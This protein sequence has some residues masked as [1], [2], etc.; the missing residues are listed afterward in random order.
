MSFCIRGGRHPAALVFSAFG[1]RET[2]GIVANSFRC[3]YDTRTRSR[4]FFMRKKKSNNDS[5]S[6]TQVKAKFEF[7]ARGKNEAEERI[8][9]GGKLLEASRFLRFR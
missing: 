6:S 4:F 2:F 5:R 3:M 7:L 9:G 1:R 8:R